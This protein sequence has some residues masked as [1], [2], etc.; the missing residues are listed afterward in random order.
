MGP[1]LDGRLDIL[2]VKHECIGNCWLISSRKNTS[3]EYHA[4][5]PS[6]L[7]PPLSSLVLGELML[8]KTGLVIPIRK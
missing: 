7:F 5:T 3:R 8:H 4:L 6:F 1:C 2:F